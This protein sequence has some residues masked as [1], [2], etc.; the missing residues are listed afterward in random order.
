[1]LS[2]SVWSLIASLFSVFLVQGR[3][4]SRQLFVRV[5]EPPA[6]PEHVGDAL[7][8]VHGDEEPD[9]LRPLQLRLKDDGERMLA[10]VKVGSCSLGES[11]LKGNSGT[12]ELEVSE[13]ASQY[14]FLR[15]EPRSG[16][17]NS[18]DEKDVAI[19]F[20]RDKWN[21][22][23]P[24][25]IITSIQQ[26]VSCRLKGSLVVGGPEERHVDIVCRINLD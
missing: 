15:V 20:D 21:S 3:S 6:P 12:F 5:P 26:R 10:M 14:D 22:Y 7:D 19:I 2:I 9:E 13:A 23:E 1:M 24:T 16:S 8:F 25:G 17:L 4:W 11:D 18:A